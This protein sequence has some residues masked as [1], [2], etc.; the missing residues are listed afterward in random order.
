VEEIRQFLKCV[1]E[2]KPTP[3]TGKDGRAA[4]ALGYAA[5]R[6]LKENRPVKVSEIG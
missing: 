5:G 2:D 1:R 4:V 3:T 6:S